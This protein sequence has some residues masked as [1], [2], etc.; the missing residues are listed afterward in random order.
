MLQSQYNIFFSNESFNIEFDLLK[1]K[2]GLHILRAINHPLRL[3]M[4][5]LI[6]K[7]K[8]MTVTEV[9]T[10]LKI[11][12]AVASQHLAILRKAGFVITKRESK[13]VYYA[14]SYHFMNQFANTINNLFAE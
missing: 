13:F 9:F 7:N 14:L 12:Q 4:L 2:K 6:D 5:K 11:E 8:R 1:N 10:Q 3:D